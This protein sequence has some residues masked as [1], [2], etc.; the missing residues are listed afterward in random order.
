MKSVTKYLQFCFL[1]SSQNL[2]GEKKESLR[3]IRYFLKP[4]SEANEAV[5]ANLFPY[6]HMRFARKQQLHLVVDLSWY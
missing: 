4:N 2:G 3:P 5:V 6:Q 1:C